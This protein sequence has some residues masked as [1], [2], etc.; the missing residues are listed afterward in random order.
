MI[1]ISTITIYDRHSA[2]CKCQDD[3][4]ANIVIAVSGSAGPKL[5]YASG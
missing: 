3:E 5:G 2:G 4:T 1:P